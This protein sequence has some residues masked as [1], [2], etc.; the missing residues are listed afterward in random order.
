MKEH[1]LYPAI[2]H[3]ADDGISIEFPDLSGCLSCADTEEEALAM[4]KEA[5]QLHLYGMEEDGDT[6]P[7]PSNLRNI[8]LEPNEVVISIEVWMPPFRDKMA[9]KSVNK[10]LTLPKWLNDLA[11]RNKVNFS[12]V[13]QSALKKH[14]GIVDFKRQTKKQP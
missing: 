12:S 10:M 13:L 11:E 14:L 5:L 2:F 4:A 6:I 9:N 8:Q 3:F 1:Y 7:E